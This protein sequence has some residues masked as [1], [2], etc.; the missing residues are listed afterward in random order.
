MWEFISQ[1]HGIF[2]LGPE[3]RLL[4]CVLVLQERHSSPLR[5]NTPGFRCTACGQRHGVSLPRV[6]TPGWSCLCAAC[7]PW[8]RLYTPMS[9]HA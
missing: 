1:L 2:L 6:S 7:S 8:L 4:A 5:C 9:I 3:A